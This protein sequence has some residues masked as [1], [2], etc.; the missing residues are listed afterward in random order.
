[1]FARSGFTPDVTGDSQHMGWL[2]HIEATAIVRG[3]RDQAAAF[4]HQPG[5][6]TWEPKCH[7][8]AATSHGQIID[9]GYMLGKP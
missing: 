1:M 7:C 8:I 5:I 4:N 9:R 3:R 2:G 6:V